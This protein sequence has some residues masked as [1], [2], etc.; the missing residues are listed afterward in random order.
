MNKK[1]GGEDMGASAVGEG[2]HRIQGP[3]GINTAE[4]EIFEDDKLWYFH[5]S[6]GEK[7]GPFRYAS[8]ARSNLESLMASLEARLKSEE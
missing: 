5:N 7:I 8:E 3:E 1:Q 4:N 2:K 6:H